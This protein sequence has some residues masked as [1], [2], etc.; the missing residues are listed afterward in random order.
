MWVFDYTPS[1]LRNVD[2]TTRLIFP[3]LSM[4]IGVL[5]DKKLLTQEE[6]IAKKIVRTLIII[7]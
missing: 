7:F 3:Q 5:S 4:V 6:F 1:N 2:S